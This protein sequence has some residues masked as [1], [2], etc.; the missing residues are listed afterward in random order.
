MHK[1]DVFVSMCA[2]FIAALSLAALIM[3]A[4]MIA[5]QQCNKPVKKHCSPFVAGFLQCNFRP[6]DCIECQV[7]ATALQARL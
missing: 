3:A 6:T 4:L 2:C 7:M 1:Y 5:V